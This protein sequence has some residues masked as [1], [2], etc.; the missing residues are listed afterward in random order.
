VGSRFGKGLAAQ[1]D[2][3][4]GVPREALDGAHEY[5][6]LGAGRIVC[7]FGQCRFCE[8]A[9]APCVAGSEMG[10]GSQDRPSMPSLAI[11][12]RRQ[13]AG[14]LAELGSDDGRPPDARGGG[15][16][17]ERRGDA[18]VRTLRREGKV[19]GAL[20]WIANDLREERVARAPCLFVGALVDARSQERMGEPQTIR[21]SL[22]DPG[23][24]RGLERV[25]RA[26]LAQRAH[27]SLAQRGQEHERTSRRLRQR[28]DTSAKELVQ[29]LRYGEWL[30]RVEVL[31]E[32]SCDL[33]RVERIA[34]RHVVYPQQR[35][36][37][38]D[39]LEPLADDGLQRAGA[40][41]A[42]AQ[43]VQ[44]C[45]RERELEWRSLAPLAESPRQQDPERRA[46][47]PQGEGER[48]GGGAI[49]PLHVVHGQE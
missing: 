5:E 39:A 36:S 1:G 20:Q 29:R 30:H 18:C 41:R 32:C 19:T 14:E 28:G 22:D 9:S 31:W 34:P 42:N 13:A 45:R 8:L 12:V 6:R 2:R 23:G 48:V 33:E 38:E 21:D 15:S 4:V 27:I 3:A 17:V 40:Q 26:R 11:V 44:R 49:E 24:H 16:L 37:R 46:Q 7:G 10:S 35:R 43:P 25:L 47:S